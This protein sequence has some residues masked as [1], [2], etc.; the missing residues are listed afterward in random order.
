MNV[1]VGDGSVGWNEYAPYDVILV[2]CA[3]PDVPKS[4]IS[5]LAINGRLVIPVSKSGLGHE[6]LVRI[7]RTSDNEYRKEFI[8]DVRFVPLVGKEGY[9]R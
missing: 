5:Q 9:T 6:E 2:A 4:L 1:G 3:A 7:T 8:L